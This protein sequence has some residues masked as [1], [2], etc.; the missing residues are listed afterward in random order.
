MRHHRR[1]KERE[2]GKPSA[3]AEQHCSLTTERES[4]AFFRLGRGPKNELLR[5]LG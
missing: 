1:S 3:S 2:V 5:R 4:L